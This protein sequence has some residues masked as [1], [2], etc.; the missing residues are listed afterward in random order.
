MVS[1]KHIFLPACMQEVY[2]IFLRD[3]CLANLCDYGSK[4]IVSLESRVAR[5]SSL[6]W[7][8]PEGPPSPQGKYLSKVYFGFSQMVRESGSEQPTLD[9]VLIDIKLWLWTMK[10]SSQV[11][12]RVSQAWW[13]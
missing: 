13:L 9:V 2:C 8:C 6:L 11:L 3:L 1:C 10:W 12:T 4:L 5:D 7:L